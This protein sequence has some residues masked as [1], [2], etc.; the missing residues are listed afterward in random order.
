[1]IRPALVALGLALTSTQALTQTTTAKSD[2]PVTSQIISF[3]DQ[4]LAR[5]YALC[6]REDVG[7]LDKGCLVIKDQWFAY[8]PNTEVDR[9]F[10]ADV[11]KKSEM[12]F[13]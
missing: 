7:R 3:G 12:T 8:A 6:M 13:K 10:I 5:A 1:M 11:A 4:R 9:S 2:G